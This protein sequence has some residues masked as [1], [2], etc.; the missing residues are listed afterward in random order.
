MAKQPRIPN[1][2]WLSVA[3]NLNLLDLLALKGTS[4]RFYSLLTTRPTAKLSFPQFKATWI[5]MR[6]HHSESPVLCGE[7]EDEGFGVN[8]LLQDSD[9]STDF[10]L[11]FQSKVQL[12]LSCCSTSYQEMYDFLVKERLDTLALG[13]LHKTTGTGDF[14]GFDPSSHS[15]YGLIE[16]CRAADLVLVDA[17]LNHERVN[18]NHGSDYDDTLS[19]M[20][21]AIGVGHTAIVKRLLAH[22]G[23]DA[24]SNGTFQFIQQAALFGHNQIV[25]LFLRHPQVDPS[26]FIYPIFEAAAASRNDAM[27]QLILSDPRVLMLEDDANA[28]VLA[29]ERGSIEMVRMLL[30]DGRMDP[31]RNNNQ[32]LETAIVT[33]NRDICQLLLLD[34]RINP[35]FNDNQCVLLAAQYDQPEILALLLQHPRID[36]FLNMD[37]AIETAALYGNSTCLKMLL[38]SSPLEVTLSACAV[39]EM[40]QSAQRDGFSDIV[41]ILQSSSVVL[42]HSE[43]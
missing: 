34:S 39:D 20:Y 1:E 25:S 6:H 33:A 12:D 28:L 18:P 3:Q 14:K 42:V 26:F 9:F 8:S 11:V 35:S 19:A 43:F 36:R 37:N 40:I 13:L 29:V 7:N 16:A 27:L 32:A 23:F 41:D 31:T 2:L 15:N 30:E 22:E 5:S 21:Q 17:L 4:R 38:A 24:T 10:K